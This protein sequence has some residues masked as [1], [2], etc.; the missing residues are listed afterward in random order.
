MEGG[1]CVVEKKLG[2]RDGIELD[3][4]VGALPGGGEVKTW[5]ALGTTAAVSFRTGHFSTAAILRNTSPINVRSSKR[6]CT[7][8]SNCLAMT[9]RV[10]SMRG[11]ETGLSLPDMALIPNW[12][13]PSL[14]RE[15]IYY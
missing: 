3:V 11:V 2:G 9:C 7:K 12:Y 1:C 13:L 5:P 14:E 15:V 8:L 4:G 10:S 6:S